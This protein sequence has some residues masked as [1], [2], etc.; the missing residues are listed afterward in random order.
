ML[1]LPCKIGFGQRIVCGGVGG[2]IVVLALY[3]D[4]PKKI[5]TIYLSIVASPSNFGSS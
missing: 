5:T 1:G 3:I 2:R 4:E